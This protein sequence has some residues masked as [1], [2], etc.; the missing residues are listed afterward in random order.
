LGSDLRIG[1]VVGLAAEARVAHRLPWP[2][3]VGGGSNA[4]ASAAAERLVT[5]GV[6]ALISFGLAGGLI[7]EL[8]PGRLVVPHTVHAAGTSYPTDPG[9]SKLLGGVTADVLYGTDAV[10]VGEQAKRDAHA[11]TGATAVDVES[12]A[13]A[14]VAASR[15][16]RFAVLRAICDPVERSLPPAAIAALDTRGGIGLLRVVRSV[17]AEPGQ[18][19]ALIALAADAAAARRA[20]VARVR[21]IVQALAESRRR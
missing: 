13:V 20:L 12:G 17:A 21:L 1:V 19:P 4:G 11:R 9:I 16:L 18:L 7:A 2:V 10:V 3:A 15:H 8:R 14:R 6:E 5:Q